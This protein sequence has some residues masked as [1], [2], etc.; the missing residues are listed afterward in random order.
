[1]RVLSSILLDVPRRQLRLDDLPERISAAQFWN[2]VGTVEHETL[3][4]NRG[5]YAM[6]TSALSVLS[7]RQLLMTEIRFWPSPTSAVLCDFEGT[8]R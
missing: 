4:F 7:G 1:M 6:P 3:E 8:R 5:P 2:L